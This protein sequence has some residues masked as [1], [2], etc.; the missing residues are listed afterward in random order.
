MTLSSVVAA[1]VRP[2]PPAVCSRL[3]RCGFIGLL[4]LLGED[5]EL[6]TKDTSSTKSITSFILFVGGR[7]EEVS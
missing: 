4:L 5:D 2:P 3:F 7:G 6:P 1:V